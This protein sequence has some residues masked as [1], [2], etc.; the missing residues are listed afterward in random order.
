MIRIDPG[1][2]NCLLLCLCQAVLAER[3]FSTFWF[4][5]DFNET[6][7]RETTDLQRMI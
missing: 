5:V 2:L 1:A 4:P 3:G 6:P 7:T